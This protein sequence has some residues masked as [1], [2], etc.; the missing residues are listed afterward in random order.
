MTVLPGSLDYLY[1]NGI[2]DHIPY[3]AYQMPAAVMSGTQ[4]LNAARQGQLY[5]NTYIQEL[6]GMIGQY[7]ENSVREPEIL[8]FDQEAEKKILEIEHQ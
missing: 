5:E 8:L 1:Y 4:Y 6:G 2:I 3:E 7:G